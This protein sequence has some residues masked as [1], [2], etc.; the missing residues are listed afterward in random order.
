M[1]T[2]ALLILAIPAFASSLAGEEMNARRILELSRLPDDR[3]IVPEALQVLLQATEYATRTI[4]LTPDGRKSH[5]MY[6]AQEKLVRGKYIVTRGRPPGVPGEL[7]MVTWYD[8]PTQTYRKAVCLNVPRPLQVY[9]SIGIRLRDTHTLSWT[10]LG[11]LSASWLSIERHA[12]EKATFR[13]IYLS[14]GK[15]TRTI[16][17]ESTPTKSPGRR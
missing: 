8:D 14:N 16:L 5:Q 11:I 9:H 10:G 4:T 1:K 15:V 13:E 2:L 3:N 17:G 12:P 7:I 6:L